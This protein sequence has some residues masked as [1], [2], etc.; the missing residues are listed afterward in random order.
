MAPQMHSQTGTNRYYQDPGIARRKAIDDQRAAEKAAEKQAAEQLEQRKADAVVEAKKRLALKKS[1][2]LYTE[3]KGNDSPAVVEQK[4]RAAWDEFHRIVTDW[5]AED[6]HLLYEFLSFHPKADLTKV[7][8]FLSAAEWMNNEID[9]AIEEVS[10]KPVAPAPVPESKK[11][12]FCADGT[13]LLE[14]NP[15]KWS[16]DPRSEY[17]RF[18][19]KKMVD[20]ASKEIAQGLDWNLIRQSADNR[21]LNDAAQKVLFEELGQTN[22]PINMANLRALAVKMWKEQII[23]TDAEREA[24]EMDKCLTGDA[25][26]KKFPALGNPNMRDGGR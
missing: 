21:P 24:L 14:R 8:T 16:S 22:K 6:D 4:C 9:L 2:W 3:Y 19:R 5:S 7:S 15:H 18:E 11:P 1:A 10:P 26:L 12:K 17:C 13:P 23:L 25:L 20:A